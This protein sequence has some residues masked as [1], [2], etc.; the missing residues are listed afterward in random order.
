M[1]AE[2]G[3]APPSQSRFS[4]RGTESSTT[5]PGSSSTPVSR[6]PSRNGHPECLIPS[7][8]KPTPSRSSS[9]IPRRSSAA[10]SQRDQNAGEKHSTVSSMHFAGHVKNACKFSAHRTRFKVVVLLL[11][12]ESK[13]LSESDHQRQMK[14]EVLSGLAPIT[15]ALF[16]PESEAQ[17]FCPV[18][19][20]YSLSRRS[21][22][23]PPVSIA[24]CL[25]GASCR[26]S[27]IPSSAFEFDKVRPP[28]THC[29]N[30]EATR[31]GL[32]HRLHRT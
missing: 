22:L 10:A 7:P 2:G 9:L 29:C 23:H 15:E 18:L 19:V 30:H 32:V 8:H 24:L 14:Q 20:S 13:W 12:R 1:A 6:R 28:S 16:W 17:S 26:N 31:S 25:S 27:N 21:A 4:V 5:Q 3:N 11:Q